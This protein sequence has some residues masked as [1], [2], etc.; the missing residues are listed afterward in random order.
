MKNRFIRSTLAFGLVLFLSFAVFALAQG[1][2]SAP[3]AGAAPR[4]AT[5]AANAAAVDVNGKK[6][7]P[8]DF[9]GIWIRRGGNRGF[10]PPN[11]WPP[12]TPAGEAVIKARIPTPGYNRHPLVKKIDD[13]KDTNDP[14][15]ECNPKGF[16]RIVLDTAHDYNEWVTLPDRMYN[17]WQE[18]RVPREIW[19]DGRKVPSGQQ[20]E[21]LGPSW[22]GESVGHWEGDTLVVTTVGLDDR[23]WL[24]Q[25]AFPKSFNAKI[26]ERYKM[27]DPNTLELQLTLTDPEMYTKPWVSDLK[28]W[29]KE[30]RKNV[31][32]NGWYGLFSG[33]GE[34]ICAPMNSNPLIS[35]GKGGD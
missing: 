15:F 27:T 24:D 18:A 17:L 19:L 1:Q 3:A 29:K 34:L 31:T 8:H 33:L 28:T 35:S 25:Y 7:N 5:P 13:P 9:S 26:E 32:W 23:A 11:S 14:T 12:L 6:F 30:P 2:R 20:L 4:A 10:G 16:P 22:Y 21:D